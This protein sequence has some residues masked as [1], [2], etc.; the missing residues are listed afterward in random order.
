[1]VKPLAFLILILHWFNPLVWIAFTLMN[2][3]MEMSC[4]EKVLKE[5]GTGIKKAYSRSLLAFP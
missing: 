3:D 4:D 2:R 1:M 5:M